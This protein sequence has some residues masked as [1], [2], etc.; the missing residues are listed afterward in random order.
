MHSAKVTVEPRALRG[1]P[2]N[3]LSNGTV[4]RSRNHGPAEDIAALYPR[5]KHEE[6]A[7]LCSGMGG[8]GKVHHAAAIMREHEKDEEQAESRS[9]NDEEIGRSQILHV[10]LQKRL[11]GL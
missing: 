8:N 6:A 9:G 11:P 3:L 1:C 4:L 10:I 5:E 7:A 2:W